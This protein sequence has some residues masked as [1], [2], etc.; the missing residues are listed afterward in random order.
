MRAGKLIVFE[1][2]EGTGK[3]TQLNLAAAYLR[4]ARLDVVTAREPGGTAVGELLRQLL[5]RRQK[6]DLT[7]HAELFLYLA[8]RAQ[9]VAEVIKPALAR[10]TVVLLDRYV[11]STLA[12]QGYGLAVDL[13]GGTA[14]ENLKR[15]RLLCE[16]TAAGAWPDVVFLLDLDAEQG[17]RRNASKVS[18]RI[19]ERELIFH[20]RVR[21]GF[22]ALARAE[23]EVFR[24]IDAGRP[25]EEVFDE[26]KENLR[27]LFKFG[28]M[29]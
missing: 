16:A 25:V 12:Y 24:V 11:H 20:R 17:L 27:K 5:L 14:E 26:V 3:T 22:L 19:E 1:G 9:L 21:D 6:P 29:G 23:P 13:A 10:G 15:V 18:D 7:A 4:E 8:A 28:S 2:G